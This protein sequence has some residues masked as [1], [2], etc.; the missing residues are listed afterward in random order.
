M[1][2]LDSNISRFTIPDDARQRASQPAPATWHYTLAHA[3]TPLR[4][5]ALSEDDLRD[6]VETL[7]ARNL[8]LPAELASP[9]ARARRAS[10][11]GPLSGARYTWA[12]SSLRDALQ[13]ARANR[14]SDYHA[15]PQPTTP[16]EASL[17]R[18][19]RR[20]PLDEFPRTTVIL[21]SG[22]PICPDPLLGADP[23][24]GSL[25]AE[26]AD[27]MRPELWNRYTLCGF[28]QGASLVRVTPSDRWVRVSPRALEDAWAT[29]ERHL[30]ALAA[31]N[32]DETGAPLEERPEPGDMETVAFQALL[33]LLTGAATERPMPAI[34]HAP[35]A[36]RGRRR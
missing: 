6:V 17:D 31:P 27:A 7:R 32:R 12:F 16:R 15:Y 21:F 26:L 4:E 30:R 25:A 19:Y 9:S 18:L 34:S 8:P 14:R 13:A 24:P 5:R 28:R 22:A 3:E 23:A 11:S 33:C 20:F 36:P 35:L 10:G 1:S 2:A 29:A